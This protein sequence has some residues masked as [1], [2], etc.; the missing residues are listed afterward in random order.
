MELSFEI[1]D[2]GPDGLIAFCIQERGL[3]VSGRTVEE[4][5]A[6]MPKAYATLKAAGPVPNGDKG[7]RF[8]P[9]VRQIVVAA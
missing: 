8:E 3:V 1:E 6:E 9:R 7:G 2:H 4:L 5:V